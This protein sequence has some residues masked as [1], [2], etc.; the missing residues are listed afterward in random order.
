M[1]NF[2][3]SGRGGFGGRSGGSYGGRSG[4]FGGGRRSFGGDRDSGR[5]DRMFETMCSKCGNECEV[6]FKPTGSK[7]VYCDD[8]FKSNNQR[9]NGAASAASGEQFNK[10][11]A[12]LDRI[13]KVL[14]NLEIVQGDEEN[15]DGD[16]EEDEMDE[17]DEDMDDEDNDEEDED[18]TKVSDDQ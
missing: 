11:N 10:I 9:E 14:E 3:S 4:G 18:S 17:E 5:S 12:K 7:P 13:L 15:L 6:P 2:R 16:I 1:G 8:C